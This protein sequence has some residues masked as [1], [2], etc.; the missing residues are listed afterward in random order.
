MDVLCMMC[1]G[2]LVIGY[3]CVGR[4]DKSTFYVD[5]LGV[6][7]SRDGDLFKSWTS[8]CKGSSTWIPNLGSM[9][10]KG[11]REGDLGG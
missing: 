8:W 10:A 1:D 7:V 11:V 2:K 6:S 4:L 5:C 9:N 3:D